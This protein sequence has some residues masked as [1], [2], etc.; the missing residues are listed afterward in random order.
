[1]S[2]VSIWY[3]SKPNCGYFWRIHRHIDAIDRASGDKSYNRCC[4]KHAERVP[5]TRFFS[6]GIPIR[7]PGNPSCRGDAVPNSLC[8]A[9]LARRE[10]RRTIC[11]AASASGSLE[12]VRPAA[13]K[14]GLHSGDTLLAVNGQE[15]TGTASLSEAYAN[16]RPGDQLELKV[17]S[18]TGEHSVVLPATRGTAAPKQVIFDVLLNI[19]APVG[20][21]LLGTWVLLIQP[22]DRL[23]WILLGLMF[24]FSQLFN[25]FKIESWGPGY[26]EVGMAY[27]SALGAGW[28]MF[29]F[30]FGFFFPEPR[31]SG[32]ADLPQSYDRSHHGA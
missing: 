25:S 13:E 2:S 29:M 17:K 3:G 30:L 5:N 14:L 10:G 1:V 24:C 15:Y 16:A 8:A 23:A 7:V 4:P 22:R 6:S 28:A 18:A 27:H 20:C 9:H 12:I 26:R 31:Y 32:C 11:S 19:V 21:V